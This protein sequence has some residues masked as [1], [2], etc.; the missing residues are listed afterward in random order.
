MIVKSI[1]VVA[2][3]VLLAVAVAG[4]AQ[5]DRRCVFLKVTAENSKPLLYGSGKPTCAHGKMV[6]GGNQNSIVFKQSHTHGVDCTVTFREKKRGRKGRYST[7]RVRQ[8]FCAV[9]AGDIKVQMHLGAAL[10]YTKT[11]GSYAKRKQ[12]IVSIT[13]F[14]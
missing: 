8:N 9:K 2:L 6:G 4:S 5:A 12:G 14:K 7:I 10:K 3:G 13:G 1:R 11:E